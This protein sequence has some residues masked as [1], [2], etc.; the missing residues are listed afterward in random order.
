MC[1]FFLI[2]Y[3]YNQYSHKG[4]N[5]AWKS[6]NY[7]DSMLVSVKIVVFSGQIFQ[8]S[9]IVSFCICIYLFLQVSFHQSCVGTLLF[10]YKSL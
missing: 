8:K 2:N 5:E 4:T 1:F 6:L 9:F 10:C 7:S 3:L